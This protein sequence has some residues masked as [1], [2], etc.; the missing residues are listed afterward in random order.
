MNPWRTL[1]AAYKDLPDTEKFLA[2]YSA[3]IRPY[4][5]GEKPSFYRVPWAYPNLYYSLDLEASSDGPCFVG[6]DRD[7]DRHQ[8]VVPWSYLEDRDAWYREQIAAKEQRKVAAAEQWRKDRERDRERRRRAYE[9]LRQEFGGD[10]GG[11]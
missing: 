11:S 2:E 10:S 7:G 6:S 1:V 5:D 4:W 3:A 8:V 9:E